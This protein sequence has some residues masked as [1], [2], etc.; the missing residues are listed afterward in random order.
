MAQ[1]VGGSGIGARDFRLR[2][3]KGI[4]DDKPAVTVTVIMTTLWA[5]TPSTGSESGSVRI[6]FARA[7]PGERFDGPVEV[8]ADRAPYHDAFKRPVS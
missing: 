3:G 2:L 7:L 6:M 1:V 8:V 4:P 5:V